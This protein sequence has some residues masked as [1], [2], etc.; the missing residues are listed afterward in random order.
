MDHRWRIAYETKKMP[1]A[2]ELLY[3]ALLFQTGLLGFTAY[4]MAVAWIFWMGLKII[5]SGDTIGLWML[6]TLVGMSCFL[7]AS[8]TNPYIVTFDYMWVIFLPIAFINLWLLKRKEWRKDL[9]SKRAS[10]EN[11]AIARYNNRQLELWK[12]ATSMPGDD[13]EYIQRW[14]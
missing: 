2:Y 8:A 1:W 11:D 14:L 5:R 4:T 3:V 13:Q 7:I 10:D 12:A 6:P 9:L